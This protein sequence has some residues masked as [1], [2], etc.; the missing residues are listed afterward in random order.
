MRINV[1]RSA[2]LSALAIMALGSIPA[3]ADV[4][5]E[6]RAEISAQRA[7]LEALEKKLDAAVRTAQDA[8]AQAQQAQAQVQAQAKAAP[9]P[10]VSGGLSY[11]S[12]GNIVTLYGL[13]D[14]TISTINNANASGG[15]KTSYQ[16]SWFSGDRWGITGKHQLNQDGL[17][18]IFKLESEYEM[19][20]GNLDT[21][22]V[23]FNRD[24]WIGFES[25]DLG[26]LT[27]GR[28]DAV[29]RDFAGIYLDPYTNPRASLDEGGGTNTNNFKQL[30]YY[31]ASATG[32]RYNRGVVWKKEFGNFVAGLGYQFGGIPG[33]FSNGSTKTAALGYNGDGDKFHLV[34]FV[35]HFNVAGLTHKA[36]SFGGNVALSDLFR[37]YGGYFGYD[38]QQGGGVGNRKDKAY[39]VST[40]ITPGG[41]FDYEIGYQIIKA[42]NAGLN[43]SGFVLN[44]YDNAAGVTKTADGDKKTAYASFFYHFDKQIELYLAADRMNLTN[45][46][47]LSVTNGHQ[48]QTEVGVGMRLK[49]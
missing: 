43:G 36:W 29:A 26:K 42:V 16:T 3:M 14:G 34:G 19:A 37:L 28:Q 23:L 2:V 22:N 38:S 18:A 45:G 39:T 20:T 48:D 5:D 33:D 27:F 40:K 17:K 25:P 24:A 30:I 10:S 13:I 44:P 1:M 35:N 41:P 15:R 12:G 31:A 21:D 4:N 47:K 46:Y 6:L 8:Q 49:F 11:Q 32:T 7:R 9:A